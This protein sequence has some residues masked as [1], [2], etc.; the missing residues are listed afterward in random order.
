MIRTISFA[1][2]YLTGLV[3]FFNHRCLTSFKAYYA[4][5]LSAILIWE[6]K[7]NC[8]LYN[9]FS[10]LRKISHFTKDTSQ[11]SYR[12]YSF[13]PRYFSRSNSRATYTHLIFP[14]PFSSHNTP[15]PYFLPAYNTAIPPPLNPFQSIHSRKID[16]STHRSSH[17]ICRCEK[18][19]LWKC[20]PKQLS[21]G[22]YAWG[23]NTSCCR[24][25]YEPPF[26]LFSFL[27][28]LLHFYLH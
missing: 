8:V 22:K 18:R 11:K 4:T 3:A 20:L 26:S 13:S 1:I 6:A 12:E 10:E 23:S 15:C 5:R 21:L 7:V 19:C 9:N 2:F 28:P 14:F 24:G 17:V 16:T 27:H 25:G